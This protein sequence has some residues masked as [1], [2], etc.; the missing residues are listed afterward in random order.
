VALQAGDAARLA[1]TSVEA[2]PLFGQLGSKLDM[3]LCLKN[4]ASVAAL[5]GLPTQAARLYAAVEALTEEMGFGRPD[6]EQ[7]RHARAMQLARAA[8]DADAWDAAWDAG[9]ALS[10]DAA[11]N[12]ALALAALTAETPP[13]SGAPSGGLTGRELEVLRL[14]ADGLS[15]QEISAQLAVSPRTTTTHITNIFNKLGVQSRTQAVAAARRS[16]VL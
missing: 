8:L 4:L 9:R 1:A 12:E 2:L 13:P 3:V 10:L 14:I 5:R 7:Q 11:I 16:G 15:N 6:I